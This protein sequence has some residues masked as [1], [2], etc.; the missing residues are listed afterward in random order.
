MY[1]T[2]GVRVITV[3]AGSEAAI[4]RTGDFGE[5]STDPRNDPEGRGQAC[6]KGFSNRTPVPAKSI[7][8]RSSPTETV[9][10]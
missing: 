10:N 7:P 8:P 2:G 9:G 6:K 3:I 5:E 4:Y 1:L